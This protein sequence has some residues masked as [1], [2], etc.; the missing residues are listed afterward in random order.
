MIK[1]TE[2]IT[3]GDLISRRVPF[4]VPMYQRAY[5]WEC[6]E[7]EE[8]ADFINDI[9]ELYQ[10]RVSASSSSMKHFFGGLVSIDKFAPNT[11]TGKVLEVVDG[12]QRLATFVITFD[13][14]VK[15]LTKL[16]D[17]ARDAGDSI[18]ENDAKSYATQTESEFVKYLE[19]VPGHGNVQRL[20]L[21]LS[22]ADNNFFEK[23]V[24]VIS[25]TEERASHTRL[26]C[27]R[28]KIRDEL[29]NPIL[30]DTVTPPGDKLQNLITLR[31][32]LTDDCHVVHIVSDDPQEAYRL[33]AILNDRG[34]TLSDGD[35][36]RSHTL[37][38]LEGHVLQQPQ[39]E[40]Y[41]DRILSDTQTSIDRFLR[42]YYASYVGRR[43]PQRDLYDSFRKEFFSQPLPLNAG[44]ALKVEQRV[45]EMLSESITFS[46]LREG[47]WPYT[48]SSVTAWDQDRLNR[49]MAVLKHDLCLPLL[50]S[51]YHRWR[52]KE[53][54]FSK[55]V[56]LLERFVF[57]YIT[58]V[59]ARPSR[60][61]DLYYNHARAIR[62]TSVSYSL[63][64]LEADLKSI[65]VRDADDTLFAKSLGN[66]DY[67]ESSQRKIIKHLLTTIEDHYDWLRR[68]AH[69]MPKPDKTKVWDMQPNTIEHVYPQ[70]PTSPIANLEPVKHKIGNLSFWGSGSNAAASNKMFV[71]KKPMY[72]ISTVEL[73][74]ELAKLADW[75]RAELDKRQQDLIQKSLEIFKF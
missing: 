49:L 58:I 46:R 26:K 72:A 23:L 59:K 21:R 54:E 63:K 30:D 25:A 27:A 22:K 36:L 24:N 51:V 61:A 32:C 53:D 65:I 70:N 6:G 9:R 28:D 66:L 67:S 48:T 34:K 47:E 3:M 15:A 55:L 75:N 8:V 60:L 73:N 33:F 2:N 18:T 35:L 40:E 16:S 69:G 5:A 14:L 64:T 44:D 13:L 12:Q 57:R 20:R 74:R 38:I 43:P 68:G 56:N 37:Q 62:N 7:A 42:G 10:K 50:L 19:V 45:K 1:G 11:A 4:A 41:W 39:V 52:N 31:L 17:M 71:D 29:V